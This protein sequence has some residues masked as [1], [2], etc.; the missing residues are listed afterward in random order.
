MET[1][2][3]R[4]LDIGFGIS[5]LPNMRPMWCSTCII[6]CFLEINSRITIWC[7]V[8]W[9]LV[10]MMLMNMITLN[11]TIH[12]WIPLNSR[13]ILLRAC[14][15]RIWLKGYLPDWYSL[16]W[17]IPSRLWIY[18]V[19]FMHWHTFWNLAQAQYLYNVLS[20][21][22]LKHGSVVNLQ[23]HVASSNAINSLKILIELIVRF[24]LLNIWPV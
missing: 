19:N 7:F 1:G 10:N 11:V 3:P 5:S 8:Q 16:V 13:V 12:C 9:L 14:Y 17:S 21:S 22:N 6:I 18:C 4:I 24:D 15:A 2:A 23:N 20:F